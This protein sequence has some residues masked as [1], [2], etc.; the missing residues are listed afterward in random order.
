M[1]AH[2]RNRDP[3]MKN[4]FFV[5]RS[6]AHARAS[7]ARLIFAMSSRA[8]RGMLPSLTAILLLVA[9]ARAEET[10]YGASGSN[11][12]SGLYVVDPNTAA[13]TF[14]DAIR[15]PDFQSLLVT[16]IAFNPLSGILYGT[17]TDGRLVTIDPSTA[18]ATVIGSLGKSLRD[19]S[20][21]SDGTLFGFEANDPFSLATI[22]LNTGAATTVGN[23][24]LASTV[25]GGLAFSPNDT[26]YL[27]ATGHAGTLDTLN[28]ATGARTI[29]PILLNSRIG[30]GEMSALAFNSLGTLFALDNPNQDL[31][32]IDPATGAITDVCSFFDPTDAIA[33]SPSTLTFTDNQSDATP[34]DGFLDRLPHA[35]KIKA[36]VDF[37]DTS[38]GNVVVTLF[39]PDPSNGS[40]VLL[41]TLWDHEL[42]VDENNQPLTHVHAVVNDIPASDSGVADFGNFCGGG[43][44]V[45]SYELRVLDDPCQQN[46]SAPVGTGTLKSWSLT[47]DPVD[48]GHIAPPTV[49]LY[50][51]SLNQPVPDSII[52]GSPLT[53]VATAVGNPSSFPIDRLR[54][55]ITEI[56]NPDPLMQHQSGNTP[57]SYQSNEIHPPPS[58][59][60][61]TLSF[62]PPT[63]PP[64]DYSI[65]V[66]AYDSAGF[67][68]TL[69]KNLTVNRGFGLFG[70][71]NISRN[72]RSECPETDLVCHSD[73]SGDYALPCNKTDFGATLT[74]INDTCTDS[75][76]LRV[77]IVSAAG[78]AFLELACPPDLPDETDLTAQDPPQA[79]VGLVGPLPAHSCETVQISGVAP[80]PIQTDC[81]VGIGFQIYAVLDECVGGDCGDSGAGE[82]IQV[83]SIKVT[84]G[85]WP[86]V[87]GFGGPGGGVNTMRHG[88]KK[89][90]SP[91]IFDSVTISGPDTVPD[92]APQQYTANVIAKNA[93]TSKSID[94]TAAKRTQ[95]SASAFTIPGGLFQ[96]G[97]V[98]ANTQVTLLA[99]YT[100][101]HI[102]KTATKT[103][104]V[105]P[106]LGSSSVASE[107]ISSIDQ[108]IGPAKKKHKRG[109]RSRVSVSASPTCI[110]E[111]GFA[112][113]TISSSSI[114]P[115]R[116]ITVHYAMSGTAT[117]GTDYTLSGT[118]G[119]ATIPPGASSVTVA[120]TALDNNAS[121]ANP[122]ATMTL[123]AGAG[124]KLTKSKTAKAATLTIDNSAPTCN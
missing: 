92:S 80:A 60:G 11:N 85:E 106:T 93:T 84:E 1:F 83:D 123:S 37:D 105:T 38:P 44:P 82:W 68:Q 86:V 113:F 27:S 40:N 52:S 23:S 61:A 100:L 50:A 64:G 10:L 36:T 45:Y 26:L 121:P 29:G 97:Q 14:I 49:N 58:N 16:G 65:R 75:P 67:V 112:S 103:I 110:N 7:F 102:T 120:L 13:G 57:E 87:G 98:S 41:A 117:L 124:Y 62:T 22:N 2:P 95:W 74:L 6:D 35:T 46:E 77:R 15:T 115:S 70:V 24:G 19:I 25:G 81:D 63:L 18:V 109:K 71:S 94:V 21:R 4:H 119:Q 20:F 43:P 72:V 90:H 53:L 96:P 66:V 54:I 89:K 3:S 51:D 31:V 55:S 88:R 42:L 116:P 30:N 59:T 118:T 101:G 73:V 104:T 8:L 108:A 39:T 114:N 99:S 47:L 48:P 34:A 5:K 91:L 12:R 76:N 33:F 9:P 56:I 69:V 79:S 17:T 107:A 28:P 78:S 111:G 32:I 122:T